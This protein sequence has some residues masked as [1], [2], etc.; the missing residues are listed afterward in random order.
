MTKSRFSHI[1]SVIFDFKVFLVVKNPPNPTDPNFKAAIY[2]VFIRISLHLDNDLQ[3]FLEFAMK[4]MGNGSLYNQRLM[5]IQQ[6]QMVLRE[7]CEKVLD[8]WARKSN[9]E[10]EDVIA[11]LR[12][13]GL[14]RL[15]DELTKELRESEHSE[16]TQNSTVQGDCSYTM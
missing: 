1:L 9:S 3:L 13:V 7:K 12:E 6:S 15:A 14:S 10:W 11:T 2:N 4:V 8:L 5:D 16:Q